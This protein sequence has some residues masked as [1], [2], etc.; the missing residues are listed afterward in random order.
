MTDL[1]DTRPI[2]TPVPPASEPVPQLLGPDSVTWKFF[3]GW[4]GPFGI[5]PQLAFFWFFLK[6]A[7]FIMLFILLRASIPRPRYDQV[8]DFSWRFCLPLTLINLL[9]TAAV[10]LLNTPAA[11]V[12]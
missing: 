3:G 12:Q 2:T 1:R 5:L 8:M 7:F 6:T 11:A 10:V 4:H 9:V